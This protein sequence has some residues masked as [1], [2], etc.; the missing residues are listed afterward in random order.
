MYNNKNIKKIEPDIQ[1][2]GN[3]M[4]L[5]VFSGL[6]VGLQIYISFI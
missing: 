1:Q 4:S 3:V 6:C 5:S 2:Q